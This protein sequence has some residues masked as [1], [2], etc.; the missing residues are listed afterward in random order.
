MQQ[1]KPIAESTGVAT[2][3]WIG[4]YVDLLRPM[5]WLKNVVVF[6]GPAAGMTLTSA[7]AFARA[8]VAFGTFCL[9]ASAAYAF[10]DTLDRKADAQHPTKR[11][12]PVASGAIKPA[13]ALLVA[14]CLAAL[15][16][17]VTWLLLSATVTVVLVLY[18]ALV[19]AYSTTLKRR[20]ILD[21]IVIAAG[22]VLRAWAGAA[23]VGVETSDW[24]IACMFTLCMFLGFGKRRCELAML[25]NTQ[26]AGA[27]RQTLIRYTPDLLNHLITVSAGIAVVTFLLYTLDTRLGAPPFHKEQLFYTLPIVMYG[28]FRYAMATELGIYSGPTEIVIRDKGLFRAIVLWAAAALTIVYQTKLF[29]PDGLAG[30]VR[31]GA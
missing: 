28:V 23:A 14:G 12:R 27:H 3:G 18:M 25:K 13:G 30:L 20:V 29:G 16:L 2:S 15:A 17:A 11:L 6:A 19:L 1:A 5:Q 24:L 4:N 7:P 26:D 10:N 22:F 9:A 21:V 8:C 31:G